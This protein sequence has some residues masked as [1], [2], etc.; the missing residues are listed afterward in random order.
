LI[1]TKERA[2]RNRTIC[3]TPEQ[4]HLYLTGCVDARNN[5]VNTNFVD[6][7][8]PGDCFDVLPKLGEKTVDLLIVDPP[9][10]HDKT[11][12]YPS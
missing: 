7:T 3:L 1:E 10:N 4:E 11:L 8:I 12:Q 2:G 6:Q 9:Y 5:T